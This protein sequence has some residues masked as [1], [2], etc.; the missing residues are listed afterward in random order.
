MHYN[1]YYMSYEFRDCLTHAN[2][3]LSHMLGNS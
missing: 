1:D 3:R 2:L